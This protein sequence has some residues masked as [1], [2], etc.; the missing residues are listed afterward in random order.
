MGA[1]L[2]PNLALFDNRRRVASQ[3]GRRFTIV[4]SFAQSLVFSI[5]LGRFIG[6]IWARSAPGRVPAG[7]PIPDKMSEIEVRPL[8]ENRVAKGV[9][10]VGSVSYRGDMGV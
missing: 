6:A 3:R 5:P 9:K 7:G 10:N 1:A 4:N 8:A 2:A